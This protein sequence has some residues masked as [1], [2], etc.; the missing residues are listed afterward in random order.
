MRLLIDANLHTLHC[1]TPTDPSGED[2]PYL[3]AFFIRADGATIR[4]STISPG[5]LSANVEVSSGPGQPGNLLVDGVESGGNIRIPTN[6]GKHSSELRPVV[7]RF[8]RGGADFRFFLP[9]VLFVVAVLIDEES[10]PEDAMKA[11]HDDV[12]NLLK[13]RLDDFFNGFDAQPLFDQAFNAK[14]PNTAAVFPLALTSISRT[15]ATALT[16]FIGNRNTGLVKEAIDAA[17]QS[18]Q[19]AV[20][21]SWNPFVH[22]AAALDPDE[23]IGTAMIQIQEDQMIS[24][25]L[26]QDA[27]QD[28]RQSA[29][30]LGGAWYVLHGGA[31][32]ELS[33]SQADAVIQMRIQAPVLAQTGEYMFQESKLCIASGTR[34]PWSRQNHTQAYDISIEYPF[35]RF[36]Y[37]LDGQ[38]LQEGSGVFRVSKEV[39]IPEF[40]PTTYKFVRYRQETRRISVKFSRIRQA[41]DAQ[42]EHLTLSND[43]NDGSYWLS[44]NIEA[45]LNDGRTIFA[46]QHVIE[47]EGQTIQLPEE[48]I[49]G[50]DQC[51]EPFTSNRFS[52]SIRVGPKDL[53]GPFSR[54]ER[55]EQ[56][57]RAV[58][59]I[60]TI[61]G[62]DSATTEMVKNAV[63]ARLKVHREL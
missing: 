29:T 3:W 46:G 57:V 62:H 49:K 60:A 51:L 35:A 34:V 10:V 25:N 22:V 24:T 55:Y 7:L 26:S 50:I 1:I 41:S 9:G 18:A 13:R 59:A 33:F 37:K 53:W 23:P 11:A 39:S 2:E 20:M 43:P 14:Q 44:L 30:G 32:A 27:G 17:I 15:L 31:G 19:I 4:Q 63:A 36:Q 38:M 54:Q 61:R 5:H 8:S 48:F 45:V 52:K 21:S 58:E 6:V 42:I 40:D 56:I 28:I 16:A 47:F 12:K